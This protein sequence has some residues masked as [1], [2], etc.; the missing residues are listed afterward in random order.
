MN[1]AWRQGQHETALGRG[2]GTVQ[3]TGC[4]KVGLRHG[5]DGAVAGNGTAASYHQYCVLLSE[6]PSMV[7][8]QDTASTVTSR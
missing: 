1:T 5:G 8:K 4:A 2:Y 6:V 7:P 3:C